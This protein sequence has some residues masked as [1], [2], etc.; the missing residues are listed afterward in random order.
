MRGKRQSGF[1]LIEVLVAVVILGIVVAIAVP[2]YSAYVV[3]AQRAAAKAALQQA[4]QYLERNYTASGCYQYTTP[5]ACAAAAGTP[6]PLP[7]SGAS[8]GG[9]ST[10]GIATTFPDAQSYRLAAIPCGVTGAPCT[11][12]FNASFMDP[13]C[14]ALLLDN[15]GQLSVDT[16][17]A[18]NW[19][20]TAPPAALVTSCWQH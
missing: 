15:T 19:P 8:G 9:E 4:A 2:S 7:F 16:S 5:A 18:G 13:T 3:R 17:G 1:T 12:P 10:Y 11:A 14:G 20:T 6:I